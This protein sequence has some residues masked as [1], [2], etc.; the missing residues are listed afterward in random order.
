[1]RTRSRS[2]PPAAPSADVTVRQLMTRDPAACSPDDSL[3]CAARVMW[4]RDCGC[5]PVVDFEG[6][7]VGIVTDR[8]ACMAAYTRGARLSEIRI[9]DIMAT[10]V[11]T[12]SGDE[13][14]ATAEKRMADH[15]IRRMPVVDD[16][17]RLIGILSL[18]DIA[19]A[20]RVTATIAPSAE[21]VATTLAGI[22]RHRHVHEMRS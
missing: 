21:E 5:V 8:D 11:Q 12:I 13:M 2:K 7:V 4:E 10:D 3:D 1:M 6:K 20:S 17:G 14:L 19:L 18:N 9:G 16:V 22:S 15:Q